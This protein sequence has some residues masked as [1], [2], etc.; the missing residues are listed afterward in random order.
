MMPVRSRSGVA[1][2]AVVVAVVSCGRDRMDRIPLPDP[3]QD[4]TT[5]VSLT[6]LPIESDRDYD[7]LDE[8]LR[9]SGRVE[10]TIRVYDDL[11]RVAP[12]NVKAHVRGALAVLALDEERGRAVARGVLERFRDRVATDPDL[13]TLATRIADAPPPGDPESPAS[14]LTGPREDG[15]D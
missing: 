3:P 8:W 13:R 2:G 5:V 9:G 4:R 11:L 6:S 10:D 7:R 1:W 15:R 14:P 12:D